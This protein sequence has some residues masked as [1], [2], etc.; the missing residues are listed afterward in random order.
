MGELPTFSDYDGAEAWLLSITDFERLL[1][2][3]AVKY[4]TQ[5]F[6]LQRFRAQ[7]SALGDPHLRYGVVHVAGTKGKGSTC[8]FLEAAFRAC[9]FKT[10]LYTSPHLDCFIERI[11]VNGDEIPDGDF[12]RLI[13]QMGGRMAQK[14][15]A[16]D[17]RPAGFRTVFEILTASAFQYFAEEQVDV[18]I[19]ETGLG[20]RLDSTN[21][22]DGVGKPLV[23]VITAIGL[24]HV[25]ILGDSVAAI[26]AEKAGIVRS[27]SRVVVAPQVDAGTAEI[28][29]EVVSARCD[30][31]GA[32]GALFADE[33]MEISD[34]GLDCWKFQ[35]RG[36]TTGQPGLGQ[37]LKGGV[38][39]C[40][41]LHGEHQAKNVSAVLA[42]LLAYEAEA[43]RLGNGDFALPV[44][45]LVAGLE[46][47]V[48][49]GR[50]QIVESGGM[51]FVVDGA[52]CALSAAAL[53]AACRQHF[54]DRPAILVVGYLRDKAGEEIL[55]G[56]LDQIPVKYAIGVVPPTPRA[57]SGDSIEQALGE[58]LGDKRV[59]MTNSIDAAL[60]LAREIGNAVVDGNIC[61]AD[62]H[63]QVIGEA[64]LPPYVVVFGSLYLVGPA[65]KV[66]KAL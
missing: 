40:P 34:D 28:V 3:P 62:Q 4:D 14:D 20:G 8:A 15:D 37:A 13:A 39:I 43:R 66:L 65:L 59:E 55:D 47:T 18:A 24:D 51:P 17:E 45:R 23:N 6:D 1:G 35:A 57:I 50:F 9:G 48:W 2:S 41:G 11:R 56:V 44:D 30:A 61:G 22:F 31:V 19:V 49:P 12:A 64:P 46:S 36:E 63:S 7:L 5:N 42:A 29:R 54:G 32:A 16:Q 33:V 26:A 10:G 60:A 27:H 52:H 58:R 21:M 53:G 38:D 25:S